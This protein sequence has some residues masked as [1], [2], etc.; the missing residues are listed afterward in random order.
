MWLDPRQRER[1][2]HLLAAVVCLV[3]TLLAVVASLFYGLPLL[4]GR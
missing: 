2:D 1:V 4:S 3:A